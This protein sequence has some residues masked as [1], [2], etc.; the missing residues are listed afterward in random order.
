M[1][2]IEPMADAY[3][4]AAL[5]SVNLFNN[6]TG[7]RSYYAIPLEAQM[8]HIHYWKPLV[9]EAGL[10]VDDI[11]TEWDEFWAFWM[12]IQDTLREQGNEDLQNMGY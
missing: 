5:D 8:M 9:E 2:R 12:Q 1:V 10:T 4:Q 6:E 3:T 11:P 7:E